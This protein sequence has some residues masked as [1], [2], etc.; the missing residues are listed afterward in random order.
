MRTL[1][2]LLPA[3]LVLPTLGTGCGGSG[4]GAGV[5][6]DVMTQMQSIEQP[7]ASCYK[8]ALHQRSRQIQ[9][10]LVVSFRI[11]PKTGKFQQTQ[12]VQSQVADPALERCVVEEVG[13]LTLAKPQKTAVGVDSYPI[14]F[15]PKE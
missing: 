12:V 10:T 5:R 7:I 6:T 13:K 15:S 11:E 14:R 9:G 1:K 3:L 4:M 8:E 2:I